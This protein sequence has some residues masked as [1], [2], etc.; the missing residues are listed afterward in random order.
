MELVVLTTV[1]KIRFDLTPTEAKTLM[2]LLGHVAGG[3]SEPLEIMIPSND[4][5]SLAP[6]HGHRRE[7]ADLC[8]VLYRELAKASVHELV[9]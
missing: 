8:N 9:A 6:L 7:V 1:E 3:H 2:R 4:A 5:S